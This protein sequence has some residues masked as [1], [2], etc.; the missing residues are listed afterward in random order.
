MAAPAS[1]FYTTGCVFLQAGIPANAFDL[2]TSQTG[3]FFPTQ[4]YFSLCRQQAGAAAGDFPS[5]IVFLVFI[6][7]LLTNTYHLP[8][9]RPRILARWLL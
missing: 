2:S 4:E 3:S 8:E 9:V 5:I 1:G 6:T 7:T